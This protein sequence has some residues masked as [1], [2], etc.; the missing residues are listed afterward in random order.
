[1]V[2][3]ACSGY[4]TPVP[5]PAPAPNRPPETHHTGLLS[6]PARLLLRLANARPMPECTAPIMD[7][8]V[9]ERSLRHPPGMVWVL[10]ICGVF[11]TTCLHDG[12]SNSSICTPGA[13]WCVTPTIK[14][15]STQCSRAVS[16]H[17]PRDTPHCTGFDNTVAGSGEHLVS[18]HP[19]TRLFITT[20]GRLKVR[21]LPVRGCPFHRTKS[22]GLQGLPVQLLRHIPSDRVRA[23]RAPHACHDCHSGA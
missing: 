13:V 2:S 3:Q 22:A 6:T 18:T 15:V 7:T 14:N 12:Y 1:M 4:S 8:I 11:Q 23:N 20:N 17:S 5:A 10:G 19:E 16:L 21:T 9:W